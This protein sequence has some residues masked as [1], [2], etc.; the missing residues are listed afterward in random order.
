VKRLVIAAAVLTMFVALSAGRQGHASTLAG[1]NRPITW[2]AAGDS[3]SSGEGLPHN[4]GTNCQRATGVQPATSQAYSIVAADH[5]PAGYSFANGSPDLV[6][7]S[8]AVTTDISSQLSGNTPSDLITFT[9]G[10]NDIGF[11][12]II[13]SCLGIN[14]QNLTS[15]AAGAGLPDPVAAW[16]APPVTCPPAA[17]M[18]QTIAS[19]IGANYQAWLTGV[20]DND[21]TK[22]GNIVI[23]GYPDLIE[24]PKFW[25]NIDKALG[26]CQGIDEQD[27]RTLRGIAGDLN[28]TIGYAA[29]EVN[30]SLPNGVHVTFVDVNTGQPNSTF[31]AARIAY[32]DQN[33]FEPNT[34]P[35]HNLCASKEWLNGVTHIDHLKGSFHPIQQGHDAEGALLDEVLANLNWSKLAQPTMTVDLA[36]VDAQGQ[37]KPGEKIVDGGTAS[38]CEPGS[39]SAGQAYRCFTANSGIDDPCWLDNADPNQATV[40]CQQAPWEST[41]K[42]LTVTGGGLAAF[43]NSSSSIDRSFPWGVQLVD[44]EQCLAMQGAHNN[45]NGQVVD[46][47]CG[48]SYNHVLLRGINQSNPEWTFSSAYYDSQ[49]DA[50]QPGPTEAVATA[51]FA[52][53]DMGSQVDARANGCTATALADAAQSYETANNDPNG[54]LPEL[55]EFACSGDFAEI[56][57]TQSA[58]PP[59]YEATI[60]FAKSNS[61]WHEI[62]TAD[63]INPGD[64]G[65]SVTDGTAIRNQL[66]SEAGPVGSDTVGPYNVDF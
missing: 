55:N 52:N 45:D 12:N 15:L 23:L 25:S 16:V 5:A 35:R 39:D 19:T 2:L 13:M 21:V 34:G 66:N 43:V 64:F 17:Q 53:P 63:Y 40:L 54:A 22:G 27:A 29:Q 41:V 20:A 32:G 61:G 58:P 38:S 47:G 26:L 14:A 44:G 28:A 48:N 3:Y 42:R 51:W 59:G 46:Y 37:P 9:L 36:P 10:G 62:G 24:D 7:C 11:E 60:A 33:L 1:P 49:T 65:I 6:A 30:A 31:P 8:G 4:D 57:F 18:R 56:V 50:Y